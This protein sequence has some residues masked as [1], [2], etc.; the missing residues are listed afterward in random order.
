[1]VQSEIQTRLRAVTEAAGLTR[2]DVI[3]GWR[4]VI[5]ADIR[6][7]HAED[8]S[9]LPLHTLRDE[10]AW[11]IAGSEH[12]IKNAAA[13]DGHTDTVLKVRLVDRARYLEMAA[14]HFGM[15]EEKL[16]HSGTIEIAWKTT[17]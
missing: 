16:E 4:R 3:E 11:M 8:G 6:K 17:E 12:V 1:M 7:L 2:Q 9:L 5:H 13:G 15:L 14:K 10:E